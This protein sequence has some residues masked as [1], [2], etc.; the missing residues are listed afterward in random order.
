MLASVADPPA[1]RRASAFRRFPPGC[2]RRTN[3]AARLPPRHPLQATA[4]AAA[5]EPPLPNPS[6]ARAANRTAPPAPQPKRARPAAA[7]SS[8]AAG[9]GPGVGSGGEAAAAVTTARR[10]SAVRRY[11][12][13]C[14]RDV[15]APKPKPPASARR[16]SAVRR[17]PPGCGR[18]VAAP[19]PPASVGEGKGE[20]GAG[21]TTAVQCDSYATARPCDPEE[22]SS[23]GVVQNEGGGDAGAQEGA[24]GKPWAVTGLMAVPFLPSAQ[25][26]SR[27]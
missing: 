17:F 1:D 12:P 11:P 25:Y 23:N 27:S 15:A 24:D 4:A 13:G 22:F 2:G 20:A 5:S 9:P 18:G 14:G 6:L 3:A 7:S 21:E 10:V 26:G 8:G 19:E 16:V